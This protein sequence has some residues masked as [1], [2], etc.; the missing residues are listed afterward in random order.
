MHPT[1]KVECNS[2]YEINL[3]YFLYVED[4]PFLQ[5]HTSVLHFEAELN[6]P[7]VIVIYPKSHSK[8]VVRWTHGSGGIIGSW[9]IRYRDNHTFTVF[10]TITIQSSQHIGKYGLEVSNE[11]GCRHIGLELH[12]LCK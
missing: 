11:I 8:P 4:K 1:R 5:G 6:K 10:S 9:N 7:T 2:F 3:F 12:P